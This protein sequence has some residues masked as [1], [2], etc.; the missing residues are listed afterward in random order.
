M[1]LYNKLGNK[2][3]DKFELMSIIPFIVGDNFDTVFILSLKYFCLE[4]EGQDIITKGEFGLFLDCF[5]RA[6]HCI[7]E[8]SKD[9]E[10]Y[11]KTKDNLIKISEKELDDLLDKIFVDDKNVPVEQMDLTQL[12]TKI[13][14]NLMNQL[15]NINTGFHG[16]M[17]YYENKI[18][19]ENKI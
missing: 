12:K 19:E 4:N 10:V 8:Y 16:S 6:V 1:T 18:K 9:D 13:P 3:I 2:K 14:T 5:F 15:K 7:G 17:V 11:Q